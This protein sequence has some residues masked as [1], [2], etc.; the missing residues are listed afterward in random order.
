MTGEQ[1]EK[2][3]KTSQAKAEKDGFYVLPNGGT[4]TMYVAH[5]GAS[6]TVSRIESVKP[7]GDM[8]Y[9]RTA[10]GETYS[11]SREDVYAV[12]TE[13]VSDRPVRRAGFG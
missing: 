1:L 6:L 11:V 8:V 4:L 10:K 5:D 9:A 7:D 12:A 3:L 2:I 13:G